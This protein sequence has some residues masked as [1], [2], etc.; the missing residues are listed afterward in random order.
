MAER[1]DYEASPPI[2]FVCAECNGIL[3]DSTVMEYSPRESKV[4]VLRGASMLDRTSQPVTVSEGKDAGSVF[5]ILT[6]RGCETE[7]GKWYLGTPRHMDA[8][9]GKFVLDITGLR[10]YTV[11]HM[12]QMVPDDGQEEP[13]AGSSDNCGSGEAAEGQLEK[14]VTVVLAVNQRVAKLEELAQVSLVSTQGKASKKGRRSL[15]D[16]LMEVT[17]R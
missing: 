12:E 3:S 11:G 17:P 14:L 9:R 1:E 15:N 2:I 6:C 5:Q 8:M 7:V 10:S 16:D 4:V 13:V